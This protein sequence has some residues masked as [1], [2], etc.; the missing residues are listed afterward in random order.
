M[1]LY[2]RDYIKRDRNY[3]DAQIQDET[4]KYEQTDVAKLVRDTYKLITASLIAASAGAYIGMSIPFY[5]PILFLIVEIAMIF[6]MNWAVGNEKNGLALALLFA[7]TFLTGFGLGPI[8]NFYIGNGMGHVVTNAFVTTTVIFGVLTVF[9]MNTKY[10]FQ[11]WGKPLFIILLASVVVSL[12]SYF[13]IKSSILSLA[14]SWVF[15]VL[16][17]AYILYDTQNIVK[18]RIDSPILAALGMYLNILNLFV[19]LMRIFSSRN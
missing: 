16:F 7:F 14:L 10:D 18:G 8:L 3:I 19:S 9:A 13:F 11:S 1:G 4:I 12:I 15:A 17:S 5:S 2:D 6:G